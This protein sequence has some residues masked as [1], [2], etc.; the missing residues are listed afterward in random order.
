MSPTKLYAWVTMPEVHIWSKLI[1]LV[2]PNMTLEKFP[3]IFASVMLPMNK[4]L[5]IGSLVKPISLIGF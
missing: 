2:K 1:S 3:F 4:C 5:W